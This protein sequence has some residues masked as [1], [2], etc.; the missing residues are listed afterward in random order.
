MITLNFLLWSRAT[1]LFNLFFLLLLVRSGLEI[2]SAHLR[3][4]WNGRCTPRSEW[5]KFTKKRRPKDRLWITSNEE[6]SFS[7][8]IALRG[9]ENLGPGWR[10]ALSRLSLPADRFSTR[11]DALCDAR[12][13]TAGDARSIYSGRS[14]TNLLQY[15]A[16]G[17][18]D[19]NERNPTGAGANEE[20]IRS[21]DFAGH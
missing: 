2:L 9:Y 19:R 1:H 4:Y 20:E 14:D 3:F 12:A 15:W 18:C 17:L 10:R 6:S 11:S 13:A 8:A 7:S 16:S 5:L 21:E